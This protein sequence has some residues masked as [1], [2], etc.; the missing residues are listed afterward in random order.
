MGR[1]F[2]IR[3]KYFVVINLMSRWK[4]SCNSW[5]RRL[6][7]SNTLLLPFSFGLFAIIY[8]MKIGKGSSVASIVELVFLD[9]TIQFRPFK[10]K[11]WFNSAIVYFWVKT[12]NDL[13]VSSWYDSALF[14]YAFLI[15]CFYDW[16]MSKIFQ[17]KS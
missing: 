16:K 9:F 1:Q 11:K 3:F 14:L 7:I 4:L 5:L 17:S 12:A 15:K 6:E 2:Q 10:K 13:D 8:A